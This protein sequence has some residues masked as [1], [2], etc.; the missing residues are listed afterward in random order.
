VIDALVFWLLVLGLGWAALP[1]AEALFGRLPSRGLVF[2][3]PLGILVAAFPIWLVASLGVVPYGL[4]G[5]IGS[6]A[7]LV[8]AAV[9]LRRYR[10][11]G[12]GPTS[13][14][15]S[16][17]LAGEALFTAAFFGWALMRSFSPDV[18]QT[19]KPMDMAI[20]N[21]VNRAESFP[22]PDP[23]QSGTDV[24]YY[25]FGHYL[26][27]FLVRLTGVDPA[28]GFNL[29]VA[30]FYALVTTAVF[31]VAAT[32][33]EAARGS[34]DAPRRS[35]VLVGLTAAAFATV[36]GNIVGGV[37][38]LQD[39]G[40]LMSRI[41]TYDWWAPSRVIDGTANEFPYFSF[42]LAD[43][44]AH[45]MVTPFALVSVAY[46]IQLALCGPPAV[47]R[48]RTWRRPAVELALAAL[49]L[50]SLYA[51]N[52]FDFPTACLIG[53]GALAL[54]ALARP[55]RWRRALAWA[56][57]WIGASL[58]LFLPFWLA[59]DPPTTRIG[60]IEEHVEFSRFVRDYVYIYGLALWV[61]VALFAS[62]FRISRKHAAWAG[63]VLLF[64]L[65]LLAPSR[66]SGLT[67][68][69]LVA[70]AAAFVTLATGRL[71]Q[72][73]RVLWL[74]TAVALALLASGEVVYLRD[75]FDGTDSFRFNTVFKT[76]YQAWFLLSI[77]AGVGV[78]WSARWLGRRA[79][80]VWLAGLAVLV[81]LALVY[82]IAASYSKSGRFDASPTLDGMQWL[83]S[84][85][86]DDAK[87][88]HWL[89]GSVDGSP[90]LLEAVGKD[91]D[92]EGRGRVSTFT[93]LPAVMGWAG[94]EVQW[95]HDPGSRFGDVQQ[96]YST[97]DLEAARKLLDRYGVEYVF[98][99]DLERRDYS[100]AGLAKFEQL[101]TVAFRSG[102]TVVYRLDVQPDDSAEAVSEGTTR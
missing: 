50:G 13:S 39:S 16:I 90:T 67:V 31:G 54:W 38:L 53:V 56:G 14:G 74:L 45:V 41:E 34:E 96:I 22:P 87:A 21:A 68:A 65:V 37:Q 60:R 94:H 77:V 95:G 98:V 61:V 46:A 78:Y 5:A 36:L 76:G 29:G 73:Y 15:R 83:V 102:E 12:L 82:P 7:L 69:L 24:N 57:A 30:L 2:A 52:S 48:S 70:A 81:A 23:W 49:V 33:Y 97:E 58:L 93:G 101:G 9:I 47:G 44:H 10:L 1:L 27:A 51:T 88:I 35:P 99:G 85:A 17:W 100:A 32:L 80:A 3:R 62:R 63:S 6:V 25:Y 71:T 43:L 40:G 91:F 8:I 86:P 72:P 59:F 28:V 11:G 20:V 19:E 26:V 18:W 84:T 64:S 89:R 75:A 66:L 79:R 92:P 55:G 4:P 42:L